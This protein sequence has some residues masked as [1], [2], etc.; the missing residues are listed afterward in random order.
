MLDIVAHLL[1]FVFS[2][3]VLYLKPDEG[4]LAIAWSI[5]MS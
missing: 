1:T 4:D 3:E 2:D 5:P